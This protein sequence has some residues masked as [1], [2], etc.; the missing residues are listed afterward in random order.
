M[1]DVTISL[2]GN[3]PIMVEGPAVL[4]D[5]DDNPIETP[6]GKA[7]FLCRCGQ[8]SEK[9]F[10]DGTHKACGYLSDNIASIPNAGS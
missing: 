2:I 1:A 6:A 5:A 8:S 7:F 4:L 9:P 10:C 3:G